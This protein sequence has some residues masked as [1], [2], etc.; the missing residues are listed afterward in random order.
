MGRAV[1]TTR[2]RLGWSKY[3]LAG[4]I[5]TGITHLTRIEAGEVSINV[6]TMIALSRAL[7][8]EIKIDAT[9]TLTIKSR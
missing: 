2:A 7:E 4:E 8:I 9:G 5:G 6:E 3:R 1:S